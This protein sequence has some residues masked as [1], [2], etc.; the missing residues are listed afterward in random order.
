MIFN[1]NNTN[2]P[3]AFESMKSRIF[4]DWP[5]IRTSSMYDYDQ[6]NGYADVASYVWIVNK[7]IKLDDTFNLNWRPSDTERNKVHTFPQCNN[8]VERRPLRWDVCKLVPTSGRLKMPE[9]EIRQGIIA[10]YNK[11]IFQIF[12]YSMS[13]AGINA[14]FKKLQQRIPEARLVTTTACN[15]HAAKM[16][17]ASKVTSTYVWLVDLD[18]EIA[19]DFDFDFEPTEQ[20]MYCWQTISNVTNKPLFTDSIRLVSRRILATP[21]TDMPKEKVLAIAGTLN[22]MSDPLTAWSRSFIATIQN[23]VASC[24]FINESRC[25]SIKDQRLGSYVIQGHDDAQ[26]FF[27]NHSDN[28]MKLYHAIT[29]MKA[30]SDQFK[31]C[32]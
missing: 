26:E 19:A 25:D 7:H 28:N 30:L 14:K 8:T 18:V 15:L 6:V 10:A 16:I 17:I 24:N 5:I 29:N 12:A 20:K 21:L 31:K 32:Q 23:L 2:I 3:N 9:P 22:E 4:N 13:P 1:H 11:N 27:D